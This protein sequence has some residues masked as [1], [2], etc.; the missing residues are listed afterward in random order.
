ML[1]SRYVDLKNCNLTSVITEDVK[2][3]D[4]EE[5]FEGRRREG[6]LLK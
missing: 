1:N 2:P 4:G 3:I 6:D 5:V